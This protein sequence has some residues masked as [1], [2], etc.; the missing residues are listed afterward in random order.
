MNRYRWLFEK[1]RNRTAKKPDYAA[2]FITT[3][4]MS[5]CRRARFLCAVGSQYVPP[6]TS[7]LLSNSLSVVRGH[8]M[9]VA[10]GYVMPMG[11]GGTGL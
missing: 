10:V 11:T 3:Q 7:N 8:G 1:S 2:E 5:S 4:L 6:T 9:P